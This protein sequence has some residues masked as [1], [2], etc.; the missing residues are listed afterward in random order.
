ML[1]TLVSNSSSLPA[2]E[3]GALAVDPDAGV[4]PDAA[5]GAVAVAPDAAYG[6][7]GD[8]GGPAADRA[9]GG[10]GRPGLPV[11]SSCA[12]HSDRD[13]WGLRRILC[14]L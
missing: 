9:S 1:A 12:G 10:A 4:G 7:A 13:R 3:A 14:K 5:C 8:E 11:P 6:A 2:L